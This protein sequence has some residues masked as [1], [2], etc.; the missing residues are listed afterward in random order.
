M[1]VFILS[2]SAVAK[3]GAGVSSSIP[4]G[5]WTEWISGAA[6]YINSTTRNNWSD[7]FL[8]LNSDVKHILTD[9]ASSLVAMN[10]ISYD[11]SGYTSR[12][13]AGTM[14]DVLRDGIARNIAVLKE[15]K[16]QT[17]IDNA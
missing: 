3:A 4:E 6:S 12:T 1:S 5:T 7:S 13:E 16:V 10:A 2:G 9:T 17:F 15:E 14:L 8:T 11:M